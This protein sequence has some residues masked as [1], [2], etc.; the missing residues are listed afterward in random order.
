[1][2]RAILATTGSTYHGDV[3]LKASRVA[4][5]RAHREADLLAQGATGKPSTGQKGC[6]VACT[7]DGYDHY[8]YPVELGIPVAWAMLEDAIFEGLS[9]EDSRLW[10]EQFLDAV[11]VGVDLWPAY[12]RVIQRLLLEIALPTAKASGEPAATLTPVVAAIERVAALHGDASQARIVSLSRTYWDAFHAHPGSESAARSAARSAA[13]S[14]AE[15]AAWSAAGSAAW[16]AAGSA[17]RS[18]AGK[19]IA[20]IVLEE[21]AR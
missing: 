9:A 7:V 12:H 6:A 3:N 11:P 10:P 18:A 15:S 8:R 20:G 19:R 1:M 14:A 5:V 17:A 21:V 13:E 16:S 2:P 4:L